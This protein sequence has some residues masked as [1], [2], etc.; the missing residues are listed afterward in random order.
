MI[1]IADREADIF[2]VFAA[3]RP[4][5]CELLIRAAQPRRVAGPHGQLWATVAHWPVA[6]QRVVML[7]RRPDRPA[8]EAT[9]QLRFGA[10]EIQP[11]KNGTHDPQAVPLALW[12]VAVQ[13][14][15]PPAGDKPVEWVLLCT[16]PVTDAAQA[17]T[18]VEHYRQRWLIERFHYT[19]KSGCKIE[20]S[21]LHEA[22]A[23]HGLLTLFSWVAWRLLALTY[24]SRVAPA[25][26]ATTL[27]TPLEWQAAYA[28]LHPG[29]ALPTVEPTLSE[30]AGWIGRLGGHQG[31][32]SDGPPGVKVLWR[33]LCRLHDIILGMLLMNP[34]LLNVGNA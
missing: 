4:E 26:P 1:V 2:E 3:P 27:F 21:Q 13:E 15:Q 10:V 28:V 33:G 7:P 25:L 9:L 11:P 20:E 29:A 19:L 22:E 12:V 31:R 6:D 18:C 30:A 23:L 17:W 16:Q 5:H 24:L 8:R 14:P 32:R 34:A